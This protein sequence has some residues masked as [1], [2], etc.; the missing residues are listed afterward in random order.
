MKVGKIILRLL[1]EYVYLLAIS[2]IILGF[3]NSVVLF[4]VRVFYLHNYDATIL[5]L[6]PIAI[7]LVKYYSHLFKNK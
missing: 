3:L 2:I 6:I 1:F 4:N 5:F 7:L